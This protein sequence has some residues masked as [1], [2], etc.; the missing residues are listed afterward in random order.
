VVKKDL[1]RLV[2]RVQ[3]VAERKSTMPALSNILLS[4][5]SP[6]ALRL[7]ATDL[8]LAIAG[9]V[10]ADIS[11]GGSVAVPARDLFERVK[12]MPDGPIQCARQENAATTL[13]AAGSARRYSRRGMAGDDFPPLP[14]PAEGAPTLALELEL[15]LELIA[16]TYFSISTDET[17][18]HLNSA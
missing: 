3:G 8:Y 1:L 7:S 11:K 10:S 5:D 14:Q 2:T 9:K 15:L 6:S 18:A 4:I 17:R 12:M 13:K 16:K